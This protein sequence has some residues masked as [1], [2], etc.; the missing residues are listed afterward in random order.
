M[1]FDRGFSTNPKQRPNAKEWRTTLCQALSNTWVHDCGGAF[2]GEQDSVLLC[3]YCQASGIKPVRDFVPER[4]L[5][6][7]FA[8]LSMETTVPIKAGQVCI[9]GR[10]TLPN[11][12]RTIS[13]QH[14][15]VLWSGTELIV[16]HIGLN[17]T[18]IKHQGSWCELESTQVPDTEPINLKL[19]DQACRL[20]LL[21]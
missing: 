9:I 19:A 13:S 10:E 14:L 1:L 12:T 17:S 6:I 7:H 20:E 16:R 2:V 18:L 15:R 5:S 4:N 21:F 8:D 11:L 3:P